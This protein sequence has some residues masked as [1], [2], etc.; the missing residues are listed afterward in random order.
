[1]PEKEFLLDPQSI[2][3]DNV[4]AGIEEIRKYNP[5][6]YSMEQLTAIVYDDP[7]AG[8][9]AGYKDLKESEF[10]VS[11]HMPGMPLMP[12]VMMCEA[13]AQLST[14]QVQRHG[15]LQAGMLG[16]GGL[17]KVRFRGIVRPG[18][19]LVIVSKRL[20]LR[21]RMMIR[22]AFQCFVEQNMVCEGELVG[23]SIPIESVKQDL[24][25]NK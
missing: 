1:M 2:D 12:G 20:A 10:W 6:R 16:F 9:V 18:D 15:A 22:C 21:P 7:D 25:T 4:L 13:A 3:L 19:R 23:V 8:L 24:T 5:Q 17:D 11:G 14:Y